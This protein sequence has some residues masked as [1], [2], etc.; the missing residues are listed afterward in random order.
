MENPCWAGGHV[1]P[2]WGCFPVSTPAS[3]PLLSQVLLCNETYSPT[4]VSASAPLRIKSEK[5]DSEN[6]EDSGSG[7]LQ[8]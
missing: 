4:F 1:R 2:A 5:C 7:A 3:S 8:E 6:Y